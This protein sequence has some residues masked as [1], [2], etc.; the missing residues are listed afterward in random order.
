MRFKFCPH[1]G[2]ELI[3]KE[4]GDEGMVPFCENCDKPWF[5]TFSTC[6]IALVINEYE[7]AALLRQDYISAKYYNLVS[8]YMKPN[9]TAELTAEREISE[10]L[11]LNVDSLTL[12]GTY[13]FDKKD[14]LM[15]GFTAKA[16]KSEFKLSD[17]VNSARWVNVRDA[18][19]MVHPKGSVS[20]ALLEKY[21]KEKYSYEKSGITL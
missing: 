17:E 5:D 12:T 16:K 13:W 15:I 11:G 1:C 14:M 9:E 3:D 8:G 19:G 6:I 21:I 2:S 20:Y 10:E 4:I 18:I 7:E